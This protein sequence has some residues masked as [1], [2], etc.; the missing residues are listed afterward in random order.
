MSVIVSG[1]VEY[2][3]IE[4][5]INAATATICV[6]YVTLLNGVLI[7]TTSH[8]IS[9]AEALALFATQSVEGTMY[10]N[11]KTIFYTHLVDTGVIPAGE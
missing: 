10:D 7:T 3:I 1:S 6:T 4:L 11:I 9:G 5:N 2:K 8:N